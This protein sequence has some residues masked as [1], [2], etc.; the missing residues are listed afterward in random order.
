MSNA[1]V[2]LEL[3]QRGHAAFNRGDFAAM[4]A[5]TT[6]DVEWGT[7]QWP[8][9]D[10]VYHG[11]DG[12]ARWGAAITSAWEGFEVTLVEVLHATSEQLVTE[13]R[14]TARGLASGVDVETRTFSVY[15]VRNGLIARRRIFT[16][17][18][19]ALE[20]A[21][22]GAQ[23]MDATEVIQLAATLFNRRDVE[24]FDELFTPDAELLPAAISGVEGRS[25]RGQDGARRFFEEVASDWERFEVSIVEVRDLGDRALGLGR[26]AAR[27][28][29]SG[30]EVDQE[31]A[32]VCDMRGS[33]IAR[34]QS[35]FSHREALEAV[36][37][38]R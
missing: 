34:W 33:K 2:G 18:A 5:E 30:I 6:A 32:V 13:E 25:F 26:V 3:L 31:L 10:S 11:H 27:G 23:T 8:G 14:I 20:A 29:G 15:L 16:E 9:M 4:A 22:V 24:R 17:R 21:R 7:T 1:N 38:P 37:Q 19:E 35:Y 28:R 36:G 12:L